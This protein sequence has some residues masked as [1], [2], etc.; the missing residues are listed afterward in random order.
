M[1]NTRP[2]VV[3]ASGVCQHNFR[4][5]STFVRNEPRTSLRTNL[6]QQLG[7]VLKEERATVSQQKLTEGLVLV[8]HL[9]PRVALLNIVAQEF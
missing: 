9:R 7:Y 6:A 1:A 3:A 5:D 2:G 4:F 8:T